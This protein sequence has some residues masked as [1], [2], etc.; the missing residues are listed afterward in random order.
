MEFDYETSRCLHCDGHLRHFAPCPYF[1]EDDARN[2]IPL[3]VRLAVE[4]ALRT[5]D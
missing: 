4:T 5:L 2:S 3:E 1:R